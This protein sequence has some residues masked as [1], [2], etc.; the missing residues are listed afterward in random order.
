MFRDRPGT[1]DRLAL[2]SSMAGAAS[3]QK[4]GSKSITKEGKYV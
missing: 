4:E 2:V 1:E 3:S